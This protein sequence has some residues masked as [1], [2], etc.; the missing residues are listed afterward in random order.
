M[1]FETDSLFI[2]IRNDQAL[3][4]RIFQGMFVVARRIL[5]YSPP[6]SSYP[7]TTHSDWAG[8][9]DSFKKDAAFMQQ[10]GAVTLCEADYP[11]KNTTGRDNAAYF[12]FVT[13]VNTNETNLNGVI[14]QALRDAGDIDRE[15]VNTNDIAQALFNDYFAD[16]VAYARTSRTYT[17]GWQAAVA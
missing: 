17:K 14:F 16:M 5:G 1:N 15:A 12:T 9:H 4:E 13:M 6:G 11:H 7:F 8:R 3:L 10:K 2:V